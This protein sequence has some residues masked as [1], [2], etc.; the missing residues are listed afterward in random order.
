MNKKDP[1]D[2]LLRLAPLVLRLGLAAILIYGGVQQV[3]PVFSP[4]SD[5][6]MSADTAGVAL[7]ANWTTVVGAAECGVGGLLV[8]GL[9]TRLTSLGVLAAVGYS[10]YTATA[11]AGAE[12]VQYAAQMFDTSR[13][14]MLLLA[15][16]CASLLVSG[17]GCLGV[18][19]RKRKKAADAESVIA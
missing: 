11:S 8:L 5:Q 13:A 1:S 2:S 12:T 7:S 14:P 10:A 19:C 4:E 6:S 3:L 18:D 16:A 17:A 15:V 9:L